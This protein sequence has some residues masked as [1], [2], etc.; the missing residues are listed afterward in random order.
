SVGCALIAGQG[1]GMQ[2]DG[3]YTSALARED[4]EEVDRRPVISAI[5][6]VTTGLP[7]WTP[8][9]WRRSR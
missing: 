1:D 4:L 7:R 2:R 5:S 9:C 8:T 6:S 3:W